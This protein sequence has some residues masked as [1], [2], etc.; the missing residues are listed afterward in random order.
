MKGRA[1]RILSYFLND[2]DIS[3]QRVLAYAPQANIPDQTDEASA[4]KWP[5][6]MFGQVVPAAC[7]GMYDY[8]QALLNKTPA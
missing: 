8:L 1:A 6:E 2:N 4:Q 3:K 7:T 5:L